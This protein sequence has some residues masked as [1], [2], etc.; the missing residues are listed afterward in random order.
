M[1]GEKCWPVTWVHLPFVYFFNIEIEEYIYGAFEINWLRENAKAPV[2]YL[3]IWFG[4]YVCIRPYAVLRTVPYAT[5]RSLLDKY[6]GV[7]VPCHAA[8]YGTVYSR[9]EIAK[10]VIKNRFLTWNCIAG[11]FIFIYKILTIVN[12]FF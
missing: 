3:Y 1:R 5:Q 8:T 2:H 4:W 7:A 9:I 10:P 11:Y 12:L 6:D